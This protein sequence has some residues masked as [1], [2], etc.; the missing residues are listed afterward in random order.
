M[1]QPRGLLARVNVQIYV[2]TNTRTV[3]VWHG[4]PARPK[5][6]EP[7]ASSDGFSRKAVHTL[8]WSPIMLKTLKVVSQRAIP[9]L[10][11]MS[12]NQI[13]A[14]VFKPSSPALERKG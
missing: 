14:N 11:Y 6:R 2:Y 10:T 7:A 4:E 1:S 13:I 12:C 8:K 9:L 5:S 3:R